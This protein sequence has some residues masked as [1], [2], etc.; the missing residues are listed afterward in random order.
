MCQPYLTCGS[1]GRRGIPAY[2]GLRVLELPDEFCI[3]KYHKQG[4]LRIIIYTALSITILPMF[5]HAVAILSG[6]KNRL[7]YYGKQGF[8]VHDSVIM[9]NVNLVCFSTKIQYG[10]GNLP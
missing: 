7:S 6:I 3:L 8:C 5:C 10:T 9:R 4:D 1:D 2:T